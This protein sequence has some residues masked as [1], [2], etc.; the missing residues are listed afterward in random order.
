MRVRWRFLVD[1]K[2]GSHK[3]FDKQVALDN[4]DTAVARIVEQSA[5]WGWRKSLPPVGRSVESNAD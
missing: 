4:P 1:S 2:L 5:K 3:S